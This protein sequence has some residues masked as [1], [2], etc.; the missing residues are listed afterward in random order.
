[1]F[2][3]SIIASFATLLIL[4]AFFFNAIL[5]INNM[6]NDDG[7]SPGDLLRKLKLTNTNRIVIGQLNINSIRNKCE[8]VKHII[9]ENVDI[10]LFSETKLNDTF[11]DSQFLIEGFHV[12]YRLDRTDKG[13]GILISIVHA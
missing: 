10:I 3:V 4:C 7:T 5:T 13:G 12:P 11:P 6:Q 9:E 1:M 2:N 8:S